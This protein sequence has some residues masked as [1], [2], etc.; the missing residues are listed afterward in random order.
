VVNILKAG[1]FDPSPGRGEETWG[2]FIKRHADTLWACDFFSVK[3]WSVRGMVEIYALFFINV[4]TRRVFVSGMTPN[5]DGPWV[6]QQARNFSMHLDG[7]GVPARRLLRD[8]DKKFCAQFDEILEEEDIDVVR[9]AYRSPN[10]NAVAERYVQTIKSECL[11][12]FV[13]FGETHLR[14]LVSRFNRHYHEHRTHQGKDNCLLSGVPPPEPSPLD[15]KEVVCE[16]SLGGLL[17]LFR[18]AG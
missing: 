11:D 14:Y 13:I 2:E 16:R 12:H 6:A 5:P 7:Q 9:V 18:R 15:P 10:M 1:G 17:K 4:Q 8:N 3:T